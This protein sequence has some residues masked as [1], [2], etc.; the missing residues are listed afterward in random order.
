LPLIGFHR[1]VFLAIRSAS[2]DNLTRT[3]K[4]QNTY[5][6]KLT[7]PYIRRSLTKQCSRLIEKLMEKYE[8]IDRKLENKCDISDISTLEVRIKKSGGQVFEI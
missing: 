7:I 3:T 4:R 8:N 1:G 5:Q 6:R 2:T